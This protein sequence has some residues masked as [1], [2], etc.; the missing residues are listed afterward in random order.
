MARANLSIQDL[1]KELQQQK[2]RLGQLQKRRQQ[3]AKELDAIDREIHDLEGGGTGRSGKKATEK[4]AP[5]RGRRRRRPKNTK[6]LQD[7]IVEVLQKNP[8]GLRVREIADA[9]VKAGYKTNSDNFY[10]IVAG[11]LKDKQFKRLSRGVYGVKK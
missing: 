7:Y 10:N 4:K 3:V 1:E 8:K 6:P 11:A 5:K 2:R 9:V